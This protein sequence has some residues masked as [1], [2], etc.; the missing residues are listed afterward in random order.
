M[1]ARSSSRT[2]IRCAASR[3]SFSSDSPCGSVTKPSGSVAA[4]AT[5]AASDMLLS[6]ELVANGVV[7]ERC[8]ARQAELAQDARAIGA[9][10]GG[11]EAHL[12]RDLADLLAGREQPHHAVLAVRELLVQRLLRIARALRREDLGERR[13]DVL[14]AVGD[15][16]YGGGELLRRA[17]LGDVAGA[18]GAQYARA[19]HV[20]GV[21]AENQH[22]LAGELLLDIA[23]QV[24][25]ATAGHGEVEDRH[26][27]FH[28]ARQ[29]ERLI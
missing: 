11:R 5:A 20:F 23:E 2:E 10:G 18:A 7:H 16:A 15:L 24:E 28:F 6:D 12:A 4:R 19:V 13:R 9:D 25:S 21:H 3:R 1:C 14:A 27:P 29:L 8:V 17:V 22:G 26:V